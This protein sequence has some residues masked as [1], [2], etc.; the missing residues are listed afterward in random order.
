MQILFKWFKS[1][2]NKNY[3]NEIVYMIFSMNI[4]SDIL[5]TKRVIFCTDSSNT[6]ALLQFFNFLLI[7]L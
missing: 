4:N 5:Q 3:E 1:K 7:D 2:H 6:I